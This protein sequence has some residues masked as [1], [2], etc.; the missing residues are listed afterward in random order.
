MESEEKVIVMNKEIFI[1]EAME[2]LKSERIKELVSR[3]PVLVLFAS[4]LFSEL[5]RSLFSDNESES[6][7][8]GKSARIG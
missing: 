3:D 7:K 6:E 2:V 5:S 4:I 1:K 8:R